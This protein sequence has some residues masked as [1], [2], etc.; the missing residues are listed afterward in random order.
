MKP[1]ESPLTGTGTTPAA[2]AG[3][4]GGR[5]QPGTP[6]HWP[7]PASELEVLGKA[8]YT[9]GGLTQ[10]D[11]VVIGSNGQEIGLSRA[12]RPPRMSELYFNRQF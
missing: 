3:W 7:V 2:P 5:I 12:K 10:P 8:V 6:R 11:M 4:G 1:F 9:Y